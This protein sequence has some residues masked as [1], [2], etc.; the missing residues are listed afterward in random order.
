MSY[1]KYIYKVKYVI[2]ISLLF[3]FTG[4]TLKVNAQTTE[5]EA[6]R[7]DA[8]NVFF[9]C[10]SCDM[11]YVREEIPYINYVRDVR[12][13]QLYILVTSQDAGS[14]GSQYTIR[15]QGQL[16]YKGMNDTLTYNSSPND[17]RTEIRDRLTNMIKMGLMRYVARTP[18]F[19]EIEIGFSESLEATEVID[20]WNNWVFELQTSPELVSESSYKEL[21]FENSVVVSKVTTKLKFI[22]EFDQNV[23]RKRYI[24]EDTDTTYIRG[25][26]SWDN[27]L[28]FSL[29]DHWSAGLRW[30]LITST[31]RNYDFNTNFLPS[32]EYNLFPYSEATHRQMRFLYSFGYEY[33]NYTDSTI[34]NMTSEGRFKHE[35]NMAYEVQQKWG[36]INVSLSGSSYFFDI[37]KARAELDGFVRVRIFK[38]LSLSLRGGVAYINDQLSLKKGELSEAERL[39]RLREQATSYQIEASV[40]ITYTFG[41]IYNNVVNPRFGN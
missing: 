33:S 15:Y 17:T 29:N 9:D 12:E 19:N 13:S 22:T 25:Y 41:S 26:Q 34:Y 27:L 38:G 7:K 35:I 39:L 21:Q 40:G 14:G 2:A 10:R 31:Q 28:V 37:S 8:L 5:E 30:D 3:F 4:T 6:G 36:T 20:R 23:T 1:F 11:N 16:K 32:V 18:I 24:E